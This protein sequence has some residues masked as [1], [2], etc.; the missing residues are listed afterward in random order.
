MKKATMV[1]G[2]LCSAMALAVP[3]TIVAGEGG[4][5]ADDSNGTSW[6]FKWPT[7]IPDVQEVSYE[8]AVAVRFDATLEVDVS[9]ADGFDGTCLARAC[10]TNWFGCLPR[11]IAVAFSGEKFPNDEGYALDARPGRLSIRAMSAQ[12]VCHALHT[13]RQIAQPVRGGMSVSG[14]EVPA[15]RLRDWPEVAWRGMHLCVFPETTLKR[16]EHMIRLA[17]YYKFNYVVVEPWGTFRS[18]RHPWYGWPESPLTKAEV[19]RLVGIAKAEGV[20]LIPQ[21]NCFGHAASARMVVGKHATLDFGRERQTLFEPLG[22]WNWCLSNPAAREVL[23]ELVEELY[24]AFGRPGYFHIGCDEAQPPSCAA[25]CSGNYRGLVA[26]HVRAMVKKVLALGARPMMWHDM[27]LEKDDARWPK[28]IRAYGS[29]ETAM[30]VDVLPREVVI[31]DWYY[32][33]PLPKVG[34]PSLDYFQG[35]GFPVISCPRDDVEGIAW[36]AAAVREKRL[37]GILGTTWARYTSQAMVDIFTRTA[38]G[39]WS[40]KAAVA[41]DPK[42]RDPRVPYGIEFAT[43]W[44]QVGWDMGL[45]SGDYAETGFSANQTSPEHIAQRE[46]FKIDVKALKTQLEREGKE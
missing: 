25:C 24:E 42:V 39:A 40:D 6:Q 45:T 15:F 37:W 2:L 34:F 35:K 11:V 23:G 28:P 32:N 30:L 44:R 31:C 10:F 1:L 17:A 36:Q 14:W 41:T 27:L 43:H 19:R 26:D 4:C 9:C 5:R 22:G 8:P 20:T 12:G 18:E 33:E 46:W 38:M 29:K 21:L 3:R 13:L 7:L 16:L